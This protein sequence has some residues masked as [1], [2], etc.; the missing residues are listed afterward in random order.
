MGFINATK[1]TRI[2]AMSSATQLFATALGEQLA[3]GPRRCFYCGAACGGLHAAAGHVKD[4]FTGYAR[5]AFARSGFVCGGCVLAMREDM[6]MPGRD[7]PQKTRNYSWVVTAHAATPHTKADLPALAAACLDPPE[8]P[9]AIVL[10]DSGQRH[11]IHLAP[12]N[13]A[14][15]AVSVMLEEERIDY[16]PPALAERRALCVRIAA[17]AGKPALLGPWSVAQSAAVMDRWPDGE[18][19]IE[20]W[21]RVRS[22]PLS[23]LAAWLTPAKESCNDECDRNAA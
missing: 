14:R 6:P 1:Q 15:E 16:R 22:D 5:V 4:T 11:L 21:L 18:T 20:T 23:R 12:V 8:P 17:A 13:A 7:K 19:M 9:F 10:A 3:P 2:D